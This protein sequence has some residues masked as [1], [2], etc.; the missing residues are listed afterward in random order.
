MRRAALPWIAAA[1][2]LVGASAAGVALANAIVFSA[3][4]FVRVYLDAVAR[5]DAAAAL[6]LPG[7]RADGLDR[8]ALTNAALPTVTDVRQVSDR[9]TAGGRRVTV[10][11]VSRGASGTTTFEV[12][13]AGTRL[14][15]F[16]AW[17]FAA[18]PIARLDVAP[19]GDTRIRIGRQDAVAGRGMAV[20]VPGQYRVD[21]DGPI[22]TAPPVEVL[23]E[24]PGSRLRAEPKGFAT[25][26]FVAAVDRSVRTAVDACV[27]QRALYPTGCGF[28]VAIADRI[29][30]PP[31]WRVAAYPSATVEPTG[32]PGIWRARLSGGVAV[33]E[34]EVRSLFDGSVATRSIDAP[35][36][37]TYRVVVDEDRPVLAGL[38]PEA[39][40]G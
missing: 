23:A 10:A 27:A 25:D 31:R 33:A 19:R 20:L 9:P 29:V 5:G 38:V 37:G 15:L 22:A 2:L 39:D 34:V 18:A 14:L 40:G 32:T 4:A 30:A 26:R 7:V 3:G 1:L 6:A 21:M 17:R 16:P 28:G 8:S 11:W 12:R 24:R 13:S 36:D 35:I